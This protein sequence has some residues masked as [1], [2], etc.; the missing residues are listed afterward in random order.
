MQRLQ[1]ELEALKKELAINELFLNQE[2]SM[3]ISKSR[4]EQIDR[5][6]ENYL[7]GSVDEFTLLNA[8]QARQLLKSIKG[9]YNRSRRAFLCNSSVS[10]CC[11]C[12]LLL[13]ITEPLD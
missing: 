13:A 12:N 1:A 5:A 9:L 6:V 7:N 3:N 11:N 2:A 8:T 4:L 10:G